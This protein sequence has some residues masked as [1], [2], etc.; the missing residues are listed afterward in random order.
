MQETKTKLL[1]GELSYKVNGILFAVQNELGQFCKEKQY[2]DLIEKKFIEQGIKYKRELIVGDSGNRFD[3][4][5]E[6]VIALEVKAKPFLLRS[7]YDQPK[8]YLQSCDLE[9]AIL[10]NF[11]PKFLQPKRIIRKRPDL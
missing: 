8:R 3:F 11:R 10:V 2:C 9:L 6:G 7:D 5:V 4:L 1:Y